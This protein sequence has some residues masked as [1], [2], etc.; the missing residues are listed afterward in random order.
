MMVNDFKL[1]ISRITRLAKKKKE[2]ERELRW[3][4]S[5]LSKSLSCS[6][7]KSIKELKYFFKP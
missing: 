7:L 6:F 4:D 1:K 3:A 2:R 5:K